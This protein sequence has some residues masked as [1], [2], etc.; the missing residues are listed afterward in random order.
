MSRETLACPSTVADS[1]GEIV[2]NEGE[3]TLD[4]VKWVV[5]T[6]ELDL[7]DSEVFYLE[8]GWSGP[9][10]FSH[11]FNITEAEEA[12]ATESSPA[13]GSESTAESEPTRTGADE[14]GGGLPEGV[15]IGLGVG[16]GLGI[17]ILLL[18]GIFVGI[19]VVQVR[20]S[21][22]EPKAPLFY[23]Q[24]S[25]DKEVVILDGPYEVSAERGPYEVSTT[26]PGGHP[27]VGERHEL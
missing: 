17:P 7:A 2:H 20:K 12:S 26:T 1:R 16:L 24:R 13:P 3:S 19:K 11:Y 18:L 21:Q 25:S 9:R 10:F 23:G 27:Q 5:Q 15:K 4:S 22:A 6:Y 14:P 8:M